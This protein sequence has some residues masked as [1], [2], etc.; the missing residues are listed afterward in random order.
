MLEPRDSWSDRRELRVART[1]TGARVY[2]YTRKNH[3]FFLHARE[4][5]ISPFVISRMECMG[6]KA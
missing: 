2:V 6:R 5:L 1:D 4:S 3:A